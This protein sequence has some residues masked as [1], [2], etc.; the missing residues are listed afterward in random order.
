MTIRGLVTIAAARQHQNSTHQP[1]PF[2]PPKTRPPTG[3]QQPPTRPPTESAPGQKMR[4]EARGKPPVDYFP[5]P[6][7]ARPKPI[8]PH[9]LPTG[10]PPQIRIPAAVRPKIQGPTSIAPQVEHDQADMP[11]GF[12]AHPTVRRRREALGRAEEEGI[13]MET[14]THPPTTPTLDPSRTSLQT[15]LTHRQT[16]ILPIIL[17]KTFLSYVPFFLE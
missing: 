4:R 2:T 14:R 16:P 8:K 7:K 9:K 3:H 15:A 12:P 17:P 5:P 1:P 11:L 6:P 13:G 10:N